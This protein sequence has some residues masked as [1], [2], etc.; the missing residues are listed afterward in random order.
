MKK[1]WI[2]LVLLSVIACKT[3]KSKEMTTEVKTDSIAPIDDS[4][5]EKAVIYEANIRQYSPEG[6]FAEFTKDIPVIKELGVKIIWVMP[7]NPISEVRRKATGDKFTTDIP[8]EKERE[9]YLG[10]YYAVSDYKAVN[11][12]FG[13]LEDFKNLVKTAHEN[14]IYVILDWVPNHTGWDHPW[15]T[16]HPD[17]YTHNEKGE[18]T[19][20]LNPDTGESWGWTDTADLNYDNPEMRKAMISDMKYWIETADIDGFRCDVASAVP[21]DFWEKATSE[22]RKQKSI[23][24]LAEAEKPELMKG[25]EDF[26]MQYGWEMLHI[27]NDI[28]KGEKTVKAI[29]DY[30]IKMDTVLEKDD[31][32]MYFIT[33]HDENSWSGTANER[34]G[35]SKKAFTTL[36]YA[37]PGMPLIYSG[38]EYDL[39]HRLKFFEK[40]SI[41]KVKGP[42]FEFLKELGALKNNNVALNGG[43]DKAGYKRLSTSD[44]MHILAF[45]REKDG[46]K[47]LYIANLS[48]EPIQATVDYSGAF[49][50]Y[51]SGESITLSP[52]SKFQL[53]PWDYFILVPK[54]E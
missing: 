30:M 8:D 12:E 44:D 1:I 54:S 53:T 46:N 35:N 37:L 4:I 51:F 7:I 42:Y 2:L 5:V 24:M 10:S 34:Y 21:T 36:I 28:S 15:I 26:D 17:F 45:E 38:Q 13:N 52:E 29:D 16:E 41:P 48:N 11:P 32:D 50:D 3:D 43:K 6:T 47:L 31:I 20:P 14:G 23:F 25:T 39:D 27:M 33:N 49:T 19:D 9:K 18:I 40:D 22:L